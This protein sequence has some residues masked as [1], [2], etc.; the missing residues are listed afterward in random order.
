VSRG[1]VRHLVVGSERYRWS[2]GHR[3]DRAGDGQYADCREILS[4]WR[5]GSRDRLDVVF[6]AGDG[7]LVPD[8][9]RHAG[10]VWHAGHDAA[11]NLNEPGVVRAF[12]DELITAGW[13]TGSATVDGWP[14][15]E[16]VLRRRQP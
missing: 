13:A 8:G 12:L 10:S 1:R 4:L 3:H 11:L 2:V 6:A 7:R 14:L 5:D 9:L 15:V 16:S